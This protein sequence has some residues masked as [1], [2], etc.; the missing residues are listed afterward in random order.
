[1]Q[2][3]DNRVYTEI[4][5]PGVVEVDGGILTFFAGEQP[6]LDNTMIGDYLNAPRDLGFVKVSQDLQTIQ[7]NGEK[8]TG[9]FYNYGGG[10]SEQENEGINWLTAFSSIDESVSRLKTY[11]ISSSRVVLTYEIWTATDYVRSVAL[12]VDANGT[13]LRGEWDTTFAMR[14]PVADDGLVIGG[15]AVAYAGAANGIIV[16]YELCVG[17]D[18]PLVGGE[19]SESDEE[20]EDDSEGSPGKCIMVSKATK[21]ELELVSCSEEE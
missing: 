12:E 18:C 2:S 15:N 16:R 17:S 20:E 14:L 1:M 10:W 3:N 8:E 19:A 5:H 9:G 21:D 6:P 7:S 11:K 4:G 13:V